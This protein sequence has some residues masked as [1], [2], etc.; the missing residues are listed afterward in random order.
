MDLRCGNIANYCK[1]L[2]LF[3]SDKNMTDNILSMV[4]FWFETEMNYELIRKMF[5]MNFLLNGKLNLGF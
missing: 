2:V 4:F 5:S 3:E 1:S